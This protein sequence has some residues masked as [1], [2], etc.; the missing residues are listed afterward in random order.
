[1]VDTLP[2]GDFVLLP[3]HCWHIED[4]WELLAIYGS[5]LKNRPFR[6]GD[7]VDEK[8][9]CLLMGQVY[10]YSVGVEGLIVGIIF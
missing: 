6:F 2:A 3:Y 1:M 8:H 7:I 5:S 10:N 4:Y 9:A